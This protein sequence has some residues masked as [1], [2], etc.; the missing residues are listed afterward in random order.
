MKSG[1]EQLARLRHVLYGLNARSAT[2]MNFTEAAYVR[3]AQAYFEGSPVERNAVVKLSSQRP[4]VVVL[5]RT[6]CVI[7]QRATPMNFAEA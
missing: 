2:Y 7:I 3:T 5:R 4:S 1:E 6:A